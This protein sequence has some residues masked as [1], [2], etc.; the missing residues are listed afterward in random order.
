MG[1]GPYTNICR[2][3]HLGLSMAVNRDGFPFC[4]SG[5]GDLLSCELGTV[6]SVLIP[7]V[8]RVLLRVTSPASNGGPGLC[9]TWGRARGPREEAKDTVSMRGKASVQRG[10]NHN[11]INYDKAGKCR[12]GGQSPCRYR[13]R[14]QRKGGLAM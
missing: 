12:K 4:T 11:E 13:R 5:F 6:Y 9:W 2:R 14:G 8:A 10:E 1:R 7:Q 3:V